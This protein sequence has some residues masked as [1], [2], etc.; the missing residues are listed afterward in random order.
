MS[1]DSLQPVGRNADNVHAQIQVGAKP[2]YTPTRIPVLPLSDLL[3]GYASKKVDVI[4]CLD[5][6]GN[7]YRFVLGQP[8]PNE[9]PRDDPDPPEW[10]AALPNR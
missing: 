6:L 5:V 7:K 1:S 10:A 4:M 2:Y 9:S 3:G 8:L